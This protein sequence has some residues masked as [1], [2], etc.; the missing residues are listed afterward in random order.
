MT[1]SRK[2]FLN[3]QSDVISL[4][5]SDNKNQ[6][7]LDSFDPNK[8]AASFNLKHLFNLAKA[9]N[10]KVPKI[11]VN[12]PESLL[13]NETLITNKPISNNEAIDIIN[14]RNT[15]NKSGII[16]LNFESIGNR[17]TSI[18]YVQ[19][20]I[21]NEVKEFVEKAGFRIKRFNVGRY[22]FLNKNKNKIN[23][24]YF[25]KF[26]NLNIINY[27]RPILGLILISFFGF[28]TLSL[29]DQN[30][31]KYQEPQIKLEPTTLRLEQ[32]SINQN[33][34]INFL[35]ES[36]S[37][38]EL[39][40]ININLK[41]FDKN[42]IIFNS[43]NL[44]KLP[45]LSNVTES[46][47]IKE[48]NISNTIL[49][50]ND[51][52]PKKLQT[53][54]VNTKE[55]TKIK[56]SNLQNVQ[57][58]KNITNY[59]TLFI[60]QNDENLS[61]QEKKLSTDFKKII[62]AYNPEIKIL[63]QSL[64]EENQ[65]KTN[66]ELI[67]KNDPNL[68]KNKVNE[69]NEKY[70]ELDEKYHYFMTEGWLESDHS[71]SGFHLVD[72]YTKPNIWMRIFRY[73]TAVSQ[74]V[75]LPNNETAGSSA[76]WGDSLD[77][78]NPPMRGGDYYKLL[79]MVDFSEELAEIQS[80]G[81]CSSIGRCYGDWINNDLLWSVTIEDYTNKNGESFLKLEDQMQGQKRKKLPSY[82]MNT[83]LM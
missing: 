37:K 29:I 6:H 77:S 19:I 16:S 58:L 17:A 52:N 38:N 50:E 62:A 45:T 63:N 3:L 25:E 81:K 54:L 51:L 75:G 33:L 7:V 14:K 66:S 10:S 48:I 64:D 18:T 21:I 43:Y 74:V 83:V 55:T 20:S 41:K 39:S 73:D 5:M 80:D 34:K 36:I 78:S 11:E 32:N 65:E 15:D 69:I 49:Q 26:N 27:S 72:D 68:K 60:T 2:F 1:H 8:P 13:K 22:S 56:I 70:P 28:M 42:E 31:N 53:K 61:T 47:P 44:N 57:V 4:G 12:I 82:F 24:N 71:G 40:S 23:L 35:N 9:L 46:I 30:K 76:D 79:K 67:H 59:K